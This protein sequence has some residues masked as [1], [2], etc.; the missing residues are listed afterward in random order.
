MR[1]FGKD[2]TLFAKPDK[3][4]RV[5]LVSDSQALSSRY[6]SHVSETD[7]VIA[8]HGYEIYTRDMMA[9]DQVKRCVRLLKLGVVVGGYSIAPAVGEDEDGYSEA[10]EIADFVEYCITEMD[11]SFERVLMNI[12]HGIVPGF[13]VQEI[14]YRLIEDGKY[15]GKIGIKS[16]K[17]KPANTFSF[18]IDPYG[19]IENLIQQ[20]GTKAE[21]IPIEK[22][23]LYTYDPES[24]GL[25]QGGSDLRAAYRHY[26]RKKALIKWEIVAAEKFAA[27]T[28]IA[29]YP[30]GYTI[31]QQNKLLKVCERIA[32]SPAIVV[33]EGTTIELLETKG[34]VL[35]P[36][37]EGIEGANRGIARALLGQLLAVEEGSSGTGSYAQAKVHAGV[38]AIFLGGVRREIAEEVL[39][40]QLV[41]RLVDLNFET[42]YYPKVILN[43]PDEKDLEQLAKVMDTLIR[44][45]VV[46]PAESFIREE[47][48]LPPKPQEIIEQEELEKQAKAEAER[49]R[50]MMLGGLA[51]EVEPKPKPVKKEPKPAEGGK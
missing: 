42:E 41:K 4:E 16:I 29:H 50:Y 14:N 15:K 36:Y 9:D 21:V 24:T 35:A 19:N 27:P 39:R 11:G 46:N 17:P 10:R 23:L 37:E 26:L 25:P 6:G 28:V 1:L 31:E 12:A 30:V 43:P 2:I 45:G 7:P 38:L 44:S 32:S 51:P 5:K 8:K 18:D 20:V 49:E 40:E 34:S 33:P 13:S 22:V 48:G 3:K 47:F